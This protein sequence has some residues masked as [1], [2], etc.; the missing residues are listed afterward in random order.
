MFQIILVSGTYYYEVSSGLSN[1]TSQ[2][3]TGTSTIVP[4]VSLATP[5]IS[6]PVSSVTNLSTSNNYGKY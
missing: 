4:P 2:Q 1:T 5:V 6:L 3:N